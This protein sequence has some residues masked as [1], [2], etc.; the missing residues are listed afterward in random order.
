MDVAELRKRLRRELERAKQDPA[1]RRQDV[2]AA[3]AS[4]DSVLARTIVP[5]LQQT[6]SILKAEGVGCHTFTPA[7]SARLATDR[8][9]FNFVEFELDPTAQPPRIVGRFSLDRE[10]DGVVVEEHA[11]AAFKPLDQIGDEDIL[12]FLLPSVRRLAT[13]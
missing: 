10:K 1:V 7:G 8:G 9:S 11:I 13:R 4:F 6:A 2:D 3:H 12:E 5:L